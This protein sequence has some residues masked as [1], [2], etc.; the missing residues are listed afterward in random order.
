[1][2]RNV[3]AICQAALMCI[4]VSAV[5]CITVKEHQENLEIERAR[6]TRALQLAEEA[7]NS[8][9]QV[10]AD[11]KMATDALAEQESAAKKLQASM[12]KELVQVRASAK[13]AGEAAA[14]KLADAQRAL[15]EASAKSAELQRKLDD[16]TPKLAQANKEAAAS[17]EQLTASAKEIAH[18]VGQV[19][20]LN[21]AMAELQAK[22]V[23][24]PEAP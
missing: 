4:L 10:K 21:E 2:K 17:K 20:K 12:A 16:V 15:K 7:G 6:T 23:A 13:A 18:L 5:G 3:H 8:L 19:E 11:R 9:Q 22:Q 24:P 14:R 1:M